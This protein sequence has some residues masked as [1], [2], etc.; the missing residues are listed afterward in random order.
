MVADV[1]LKIMVGLV[2]TTVTIPL[3]LSVAFSGYIT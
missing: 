2:T 3:C 1:A